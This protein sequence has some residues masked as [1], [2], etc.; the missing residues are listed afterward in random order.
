MNIK[1]T[2]ISIIAGL[3]LSTIAASAALGTSG[4]T[5]TPAQAAAHAATVGD[6]T[7]VQTITASN[8]D[9]CNR[10][11]TG[12]FNISKEYLEKYTF[13][14]EI[15]VTHTVGIG[16]P[17]TMSQF[18]I[19]IKLPAFMGLNGAGN[20]TLMQASTIKNAAGVTVALFS[21][22][23]SG[24]YV[25]INTG[26]LPA[27]N[28]NDVLHLDNGAATQLAVTLPKGGSYADGLSG[29]SIEDR[30]IEWD[31]YTN[32]GTPV[33]RDHSAWNFDYE[34]HPQFLVAC[35]GKLDALINWE[36]DA[37]S[38]VVTK[39][40]PDTT[41]AATVI[42]GTSANG[43]D[44]YSTVLDRLTYT[45]DNLG[46][47]DDRG[48]TVCTTTF[49]RW[50]E[51]NET[52]ITVT[53]QDNNFSTLPADF[54]V[55]STLEALHTSGDTL[56]AAIPVAFDPTYRIATFTTDD[57]DMLKGLTTFTAE[58]D[59]SVGYVTP[60]SQI[61]ANHFVGNMDLEG[62]K[63]VPADQVNPAR[64][65]DLTE[66]SANIGEWMNHSYIAQIAGATD[67]SLV[68]SKV[69]IVNRSCLAATP[70]IKLIKDGQVSVYKANAT[71]AVDKQ[72]VY[73]LTNIRNLNGFTLVDGP[74]RSADEGLYAV[75]VI[76]PGVAEDFYVYAQ[77]LRMDTKQFKD[78][79]VYNT[80]SRD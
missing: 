19:Q 14:D 66:I 23:S 63:A 77:A 25:Y 39:H 38:F 20:D 64:N 29:S 16:N 61:G 34:V 79:P 45:L 21:N 41:E 47:W 1:T 5:L 7:G 35:K 17:N 36:N 60:N 37:K 3:A 68:T 54:L 62:A 58:F 73:T 71:L 70:T 8:K 18:T 76:L 53:A 65:T 57:V 42:A 13:N 72:E 69:F 15:N 12:T 24:K 80:S 33:L 74:D 2:A 26:G 52:E 40:G 31:I 49:D 44:V 30:S 28:T 46:G 56:G 78:L 11:N 6:L 32:N 75:E 9:Q 22:F 67:G 55:S 4:T 43:L 48:H 51:G 27:I 10:T 59:F 50:L